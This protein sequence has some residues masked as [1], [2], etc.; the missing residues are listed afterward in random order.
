MDSLNF[1]LHSQANAVAVHVAV[2]T[3]GNLLLLQ[4]RQNLRTDLIGIAGR[5]VKKYHRCHPCCFRRLK[6]WV[7]KKER[8]S[9]RNQ[10]R[11]RGIS[12]EVCRK[13]QPA[14]YLSLWHRTWRYSEVRCLAG[15]EALRKS[16]HGCC[17]LLVFDWWGRHLRRCPVQSKA[18]HKRSGHVGTA[19]K[20][21]L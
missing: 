17:P 12:S 18:W 19:V 2:E 14:V 4:N 9:Y 16:K 7:H 15:K 13:A 8:S 21:P 6:R 20:H 5:I 3:V 11:F 1:P 10:Q